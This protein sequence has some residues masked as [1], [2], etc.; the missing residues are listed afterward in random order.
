MIATIVSNQWIQMSQVPPDTNE[1]LYQHFSVR[2]PSSHFIDTSRGWDGWYRKYDRK[3]QRLPRTLLLELVSFAET[4]G[5]PLEVYDGRPEVSAPDPSKIDRN[6]LK[7]IT[8][9]DHQVRALQAVCE[10]EV[11]I[12]DHKTGAG[13]TEIMAAIV[14]LLQCHTVIIAEQRVVIEQIKQRL[15]LRDIVDGGIGLFYGG[16]TPDGQMVV[17]G[18]INSFNP[19]PATLKEKKPQEF[20]T[21][22]QNSDKFQQIVANADLLMVDECDRATSAKYR[23]LFKSFKGRRKYG[24]SGTPFDT[25]KPVEALILKEFLG[26]VISQ[27][28]REELTGI[29]RIIPVKY[30]A[31]TMGPDERTDMTAFDVAEKEL[32][33]DN[34]K[35]HDLVAEIVESFPDDGTLVLVDTNNIA[36]LGMALERRI[37]NSKFIYNKTTKKVRRK[38]IGLFEQREI[39]C[40]IGGRILKRGLDLKGGVENLVLC[41]GGKL[42]SDFDQKIGRAVRNNKRGWARVFSFFFLNNNYLY[43]HSKEQLKFVVNMGYETTVIIGGEEVDGAKFVASRFRL[44]KSRKP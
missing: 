42:E 10:H 25:K 36:D 21:K 16:E 32:I 29:G 2:H 9:E 20:F 6:M 40:L 19:P 7:G 15:E 39:K 22:Y 28:S 35:F 17:V 43:R 23:K 38:Y 12:H 41:G 26:S 14:R 33:V 44:P 37:P 27:S 3:G 31:I 11:G 5:V 4:S 18:S 8:L 34:P 30:Y 13:K 1:Q 24:F